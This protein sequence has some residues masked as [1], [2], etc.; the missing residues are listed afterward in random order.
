MDAFEAVN[1]VEISPEDYTQE[2]QLEA[3]QWLHDSR[4]AYSLQGWYGRT[5]IDLIDRGLIEAD[6][7]PMSNT[8]EDKLVDELG[9]D[10]CAHLRDDDEEEQFGEG[11]PADYGDN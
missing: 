5:A 6:R 4:L 9:Y 7:Q 10:S 11:D 3:W 1:R 8:V 2:E